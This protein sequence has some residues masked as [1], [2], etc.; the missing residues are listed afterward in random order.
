MS[1]K[2]YFSQ[3]DL[4]DIF[5]E[6]PNKKIVMDNSIKYGPSMP[7]GDALDD[8]IINKSSTKRAKDKL[9]LE[10]LKELSKISK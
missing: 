7:K 3:K 4:Y 10:Q 2:V 9:D 1:K 5:K 6:S 8:L